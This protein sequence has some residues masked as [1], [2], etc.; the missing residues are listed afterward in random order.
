MQE[1]LPQAHTIQRPP[2]STLPA[3]PY[4]TVLARTG[5]WLKPRH[6]K[7][8]CG[9]SYQ[10]ISPL[11][12]NPSLQPAS[13]RAPAFIFPAKRAGGKEWRTSD[14]YH[15][16]CSVFFPSLLSSRFLHRL[17][18]EAGAS[19][20]H[21]R[22]LRCRRLDVNHTG[23]PGNCW[24]RPLANPDWSSVREPEVTSPPRRSTDGCWELWWDHVH[25]QRKQ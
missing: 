9:F 13:S 12:K 4:F 6:R 25:S 15:F 5:D 14:N 17:R 24:A 11:L 21:C 19:V 7:V 22:A 2:P 16:S 10:Q 18:G 8:A 20:I 3:I 23:N 1:N